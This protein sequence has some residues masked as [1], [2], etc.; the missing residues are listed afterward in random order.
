MDP[1]TQA[2]APEPGAIF[3]N[4]TL[5]N[6]EGYSEIVPGAPVPAAPAPASQEAVPAQPTPLPTPPP[7]AVVPPPGQPEP[8]WYDG[9]P[10]FTLPE[11]PTG[12]SATDDGLPDVTMTEEQKQ[13]LRECLKDT[14]TY[15]A[16]N[17]SIMF[18]IEQDKI[19]HVAVLEAM[20]IKILDSNVHKDRNI[21]L[22]I[23]NILLQRVQSMTPISRGA[24]QRLNATLFPKE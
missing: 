8:Q 3:A 2:P 15:I 9:L 24:Q 19:D 7:L 20:C 6:D 10:E 22:G 16:C 21:K 14:E 12:T 18:N 23:C 4:A 5:I 1:K 11:L 13:F 17:E